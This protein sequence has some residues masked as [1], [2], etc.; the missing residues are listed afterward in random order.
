LIFYCGCVREAD[1]AAR[2]AEFAA[3]GFDNVAV[4]DGGILA[5][6]RAGYAVTKTTRER[7]K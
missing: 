2:A 5:W 6:I 4:V 3:K 1:A 7:D